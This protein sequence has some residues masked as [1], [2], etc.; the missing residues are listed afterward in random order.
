MRI[1]RGITVTKPEKGLGVCL[2]PVL[3]EGGVSGGTTSKEELKFGTDARAKA[4]T[5]RSGF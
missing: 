4:A 5:A 1:S 3:R 2:D